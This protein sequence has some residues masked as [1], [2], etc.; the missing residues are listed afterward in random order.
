MIRFSKCFLMNP[1]HIW[2]FDIR[3]SPDNIMKIANVFTN[4]W[5]VVTIDSIT[6]ESSLL[7]FI[8]TQGLKYFVKQ[9]SINNIE[10]SIA[11]SYD[12]FEV[13]LRKADSEDP[14]NIF[15]F[16]IPDLTNWNIYLHYS[17]EEL[18]A[19]GVAN[20][21]ISIGLDENAMLITVNKHVLSPKELYSKIKS[22]Q[23]D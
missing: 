8:E 12:L 13:I 19:T 20:M 15:V 9:H 21:F 10:I 17:F 18:V 7:T 22:L 4:K 2:I 3:C 6:K 5:V 1:A 11:I 23:F 14:E 16:D